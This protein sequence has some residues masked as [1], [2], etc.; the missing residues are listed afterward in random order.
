ME[1]EG[2]YAAAWSKLEGVVVKVVSG[3]EHR[4]DPA[5]VGLESVEAALVLREWFA[6]EIKRVYTKLLGNPGSAVLVSHQYTDLIKWIRAHHNQTTVRELSRGPKKYRRAEKAK[7][8]LEE[9]Y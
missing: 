6:G 4:T 3:R 2:D 1:L 8:A 5:R 7:T 9:L